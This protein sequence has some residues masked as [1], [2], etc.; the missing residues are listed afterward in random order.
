MHQEGA[1][2]FVSDLSEEFLALVLS[3][4]SP[5]L[6]IL[7]AFLHGTEVRSLNTEEVFQSLLPIPQ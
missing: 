3:E 1:V 7:L 5:V 6:S 2:Y 4:K